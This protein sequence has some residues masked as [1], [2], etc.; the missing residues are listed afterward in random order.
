M[1]DLV[2][3]WVRRLGLGLGVGCCF[4]MWFVVEG[5][6]DVVFPILSYDTWKVRY[7]ST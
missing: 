4:G 6:I 5:S 3:V 1:I 2:L 7:L